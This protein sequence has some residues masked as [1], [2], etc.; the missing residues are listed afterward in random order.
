[1]AA[2]FTVV[3]TGGKVNED[4][5]AVATPGVFGCIASVVLNAGDYRLNWTVSSALGSTAVNVTECSP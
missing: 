5:G 2:E 3:T 4:G 1:M